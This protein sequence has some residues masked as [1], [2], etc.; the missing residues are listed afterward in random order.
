MRAREGH[1]DTVR[2]LLEL[3]ADPKAVDVPK[4]QYASSHGWTPLHVAAI[5]DRAPIAKLLLDRGADV[6]AAD[7]RGKFTPLHYAAWNGNAEMTALL[8]A[9]NADRDAKDGEQRTP[10]DLAKKKGQAGVAK[11]LNR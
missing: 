4:G 1:L 9:C 5:A 7:A 8:L 3:K 11:L 10:L 2:A 6:N